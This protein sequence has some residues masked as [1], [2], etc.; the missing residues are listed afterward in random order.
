MT[1]CLFEDAPVAHLAPL[2]LTRAVYDLRIGAR[3]LLESA[4]AAFAPQTL[5]L[6]AR[7]TVLG[8]T[9]EE[10]PEAVP[11]A[12]VTGGVLLVNGRWR[13]RGGETVD[14]IREG[15]RGDAKVWAQGD[16]L[17]AIWLPSPPADPTNL[18]VL[19][20]GVE[21]HE[22]SGETVV[23]RLWHLV[24]D[25]PARIAEDLEEMGGLG[26]H[27]GA[28]V[29]PAAV[30]ASG[31]R[32]HLASGVRIAPGAVLD[33]TS[34]PI[35]LEQG[36]ALEANAVVAG[37]CWIGQGATVKALCRIDGSAI[38]ERSKVG[39]E[40]HASVLHSLSNKGHDGYLGNSYLGRWCNLGADTNTSN[41]R[42]DYG[43]VSLYDAVEGRDAKTG[44]QF[45]GLVM[46]DHSKCA[47]NTAFNTGTVVGVA[48]NLFGAEFM[49]RYVPSFS[50]GGASRRVEYRPSKALRVAEAVMARRDRDLTPEAR[51]MLLAVHE[52]TAP[53]RA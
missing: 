51:K 34:G 17:L 44:S 19:P 11:L 30:L 22:V 2:A 3:T 26:T 6:H 37:P 7:E 20:E 12:A 47:I 43:E 27:E 46:G 41:L 14:R 36:A 52:A 9:L 23:S 38:G 29:H 4:V 31:E 15:A 24:E 8:V 50:W 28:D 48:C 49:P 53:D 13:A 18:F 25:V 42:N 21:R 5:A 1:L 10:H 45:I 39:G 16:D 35:R 32:I 33:A 40:V